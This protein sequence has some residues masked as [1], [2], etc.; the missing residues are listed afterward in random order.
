MDLLKL[1]KIKSKNAVEKKPS[2]LIIVSEDVSKSTNIYELYEENLNNPNGFYMNE[3]VGKKINEFHDM[4]KQGNATMKTTSKIVRKPFNSTKSV[5][6]VEKQINFKDLKPNVYDI[7]DW[8]VLIETLRNFKHLND[9][10]STKKISDFKS[11]EELSDFFKNLSC[12]HYVEKIW[13]IYMWIAENITYDV[14]GYATKKL[15]KNDP[16]SVFAEGKCICQ[17]Y[18]LLFKYLCERLGFECIKISGYSKGFG[19]DM[20]KPLANTDHAWNAIKIEGKWQ[21]VD[22]T[23]GAGYTKNGEFIR[24]FQP[25][26]FLTPP[27]IFIYDHYA[28]NYQLQIPHL[29]LNEFRILPKFNLSFH[30]YDLECL[31]H[32]KSEINTTKNR[33]ELEFKV[34]ISVVL[35]AS[36]K[37]LNGNK[38]EDCVFYAR[39]PYTLNYEFKACVPVPSRRYFLFFYAKYASDLNNLY[40]EVGKFSVICNT[41]S[42]FSLNDTYFVKILNAKNVES[43]LFYPIS[44]NLRK[45]TVHKFKIFVRHALKVALLDSE[46]KWVYF[47]KEDAEKDVWHLENLFEKTGKVTIFAKMDENKNLDGIY[48]YNVIE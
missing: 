23:W 45:R 19:F 17:G 7:N 14:V 4:V 35:T 39:N 25:F 29:T 34:P 44:L 13:S 9:L 27:Q 22:N 43:F 24:K 38:V 26:Y 1:P 8:K 47:K 48:F 33:I 3:N 2:N 37:D 10:I 11:L 32:N 16:E 15:G 12:T 30:L 31:S 28:E 5:K 46:N 6:S 18:S 40:D 41:N 36:L 20:T 21:L 42:K